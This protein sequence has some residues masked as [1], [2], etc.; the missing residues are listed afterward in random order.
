MLGAQFNIDMLREI[1]GIIDTYITRRKRPIT[2]LLR[3]IVEHPEM[4]IY[5][6]M[7]DADDRKRKYFIRFSNMQNIFSKYLYLFQFKFL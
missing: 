7:M 4:G 1:C 5:A 2:N 3:G 6:L